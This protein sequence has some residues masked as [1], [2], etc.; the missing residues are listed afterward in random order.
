MKLF[1]EIPTLSNDRV[2][3]REIVAGD[4][5]AVERI[6][7]DPEV[8]LYLPAYLIEQRYSAL[9]C[10]DHMREECLI[11]HRSL[12]LA[13]A[14]CSNPDQML[15][16]AEIYNYDEDVA[17]A[18]IG[19][20]LSKES[21]H[22]GIATQVAALLLNYLIDQLGLSTV[23]AHIAVGNTYS[24]KPLLDNGFVLSTSGLQ[25]DWARDEPVITNKYVYERPK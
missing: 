9:E 1:D 16:I 15:G 8:N 14:L 24:S 22:Q 13:I 18:S 19:C 11:Y 20:R 5:S 21:W 23:T 6:A 17:K 10:I 12:F 4:A 3:L 25:E 2:I 7:H